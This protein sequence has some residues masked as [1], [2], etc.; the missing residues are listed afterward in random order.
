MRARK[1]KTPVATCRCYSISSPNAFT[2]LVS[3]V[4][5]YFPEPHNLKE[6][7]SLYQSPSGATGPYPTHSCNRPRSANEICRC[8]TRSKRCSQSARG[9]SENCI[10]GNRVL[11]ENCADQVL[12]R[13]LLTGR[14][15]LVHESAVGNCADQVLP[16]FL[17]TGRFLLVHESA[18]GGLQV[19]LRLGFGAD[20][21][22]RQR[23]QSAAHRKLTFLGDAAYLNRERAWNCDALADWLSATTAGQLVRPGHTHILPLVHQCGARTA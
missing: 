23:D 11:P 13:F 6:P 7:K 1:V 3:T 21:R 18:V 9:R 16:R 14:F 2:F 20:A 4:L 19:L 8:C 22:F 15:L 5:G 10:A 12:P 17:L